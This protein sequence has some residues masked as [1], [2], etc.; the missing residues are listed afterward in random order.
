MFGQAQGVVVSGTLSVQYLSD[1]KFHVYFMPSSSGSGSIGNGS[2]I[3]LTAPTGSTITIS[4]LTSYTAGTWIQGGI[5]TQ[6]G[7]SAS[8]G[9]SGLDYWDFYVSADYTV[10][11]TAGTAVE[12]FSF[13]NSGACSGGSF[14]INTATSTV[15][16]NSEYGSVI[17]NLAGDANQA[18]TNSV[19]NTDH[20]NSAMCVV[21]GGTASIKACLYGAV[22]TGTTTMTTTL[23]TLGL[24][25]MTDPYGKGITT[26]STIISS[27]LVTDWV[28][29]ELRSLFGTV[30][31]RVAALLKSDGTLIN[32]D[33]TFPLRFTTTTGNFY[34]VVRHR[35]HIG[36]M[37]AT[38]IAISSTT[39]PIIDFTN[40]N[41]AT[42]GLNAQ[43]TVGSIK[44]MWAGNAKGISIEGSDKVH[45]TGL[46]SSL[47]RMKTAVGSN[48]TL[49]V[50]GYLNA[51]LNLDGKV[52]YTGVNSDLSILK[53]SLTSGASGLNN[54]LNQRF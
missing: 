50:T 39:T 20:S 9:N 5:K 19:T 52:T 3:G 15:I 49:Q 32:S 54:I 17:L 46:D 11:F 22:P 13:T 53:S 28:L 48:L 4:S 45:Y 37:S 31:E 27:N 1:S 40:P 10:N 34:I 33:G 6:G 14:N 29:V 12:L 2:T 25:P 18:G 44:A 51:D 21:T 47:S 42:F 24:I 38:P 7:G 8:S 35:N 23:N 41:T 30:T 36:V 26:T 43:A 16:N